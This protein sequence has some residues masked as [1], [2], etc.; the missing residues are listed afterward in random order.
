[1]K[2]RIILHGNISYIHIDQ[3]E[4]IIID[5]ISMVTKELIDLLEEIC[6]KADINH[7]NRFFGGKNVWIFCDLRQLPVLRSKLPSGL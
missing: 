7:E 5:E 3:Y 6:R 1:M 4:Y 2:S